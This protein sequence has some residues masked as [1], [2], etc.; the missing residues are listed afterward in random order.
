[1]VEALVLEEARLGDLPRLADLVCSLFE[2][3]PDFKPDREVQLRGLQLI[4]DHPANARIFVLRAPGHPVAGMVNLQFTLSTAMGAKTALLE[5]VIVH[6]QLRSRGL[7]TW[8]FDQ[9][10]EWC[11]REG[12][13][14]ITLLTEG[15]NRGA[16]EFYRRKGFK[17][18][19]MVVM[20]RWEEGL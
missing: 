2:G 10:L 5:D 1:M 13:P 12:I 16:Q 18:S 11:R 6:P 8:M 14:R 19:T 7:G 9:V 20:R 3:E 4:L 15:E 17:D